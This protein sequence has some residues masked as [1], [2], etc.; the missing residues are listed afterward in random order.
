MIILLQSNLFSEPV[1]KWALIALAILTMAYVLL[2]PRG[3]KKK[4]PLAGQSIGLSQQRGVERDMNNLLVEL[5]QMARQIT[6]QLDQRAAKLDL[7][8]READEKIAELQAMTGQR[9]V[10]G[11]RVP[12]DDEQQEARESG[13]AAARADEHG[14]EAQVDP[15]YAEI[16]SLA[17]EGQG[18]AA[19]AQRLGRPSGE[20]ELILALR[21]NARAG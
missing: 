8:I 17:D 10:I 6:G 18:A 13:P 16:Y 5:S 9:K 7:L 1:S 2:R 11:E 19:I 12:R 15:R 20:V 14:G 4:D 21:P 3:K